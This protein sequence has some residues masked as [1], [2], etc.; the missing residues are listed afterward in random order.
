MH[1]TGFIDKLRIIIEDYV[2]V[3]KNL[4]ADKIWENLKYE[5]TQFCIKQS[6]IICQERRQKI[7][8]LTKMITE[9]ENDMNLGIDNIEE[10]NHIKAQTEDYFQ[11]KN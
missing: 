5:I 2:K 6:K 4:T 11:E 10:R 7:N 8:K 1:S 3:S 9:L